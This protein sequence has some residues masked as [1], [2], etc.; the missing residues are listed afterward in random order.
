MAA[1]VEATQRFG[2]KRTAGTTD[3]ETLFSH[4]FIFTILLKHL[5]IFF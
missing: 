4:S 5:Y 3:V 2:K 1:F